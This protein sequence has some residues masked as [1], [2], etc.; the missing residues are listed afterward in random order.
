MVRLC[1]DGRGDHCFSS[2]FSQLPRP[3]RKSRRQT[4]RAPNPGTLLG[5]YLSGRMA[6]GDHDTE[7][8]ADFYSKALA[9]DPG[10]EIILEQAFLLEAAAAHWDRA[11]LL[12]RE[13]VKIEPS[14]RIAQFLLGCDA[15][16]RGDYK[17]ADEHFAAARQGPIADLTSTL[18]RA[19]V[20]Q[21]AGKTDEAFAT[22]DSLSDADWAQFYQ[23][24]HR[25]LIADVAGKHD[26]ARQAFAQ[27]FKKNPSTLRVADAY[28]RHAV[29]E[30]QPQARPARRSRPT[31][32]SPRRIPC[33]RRLLADIE[34][35]KVPPLL[36]VTPARWAR[37]GVLRHR[38]RS[39]RR[40]RA[41]HGHHLPAIRALR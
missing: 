15:F 8:A 24:Y 21:A 11:I 25:A 16:K 35:G 3:I 5:N 27:A 30:Q 29:N 38:R 37:R 33:L 7:A 26:V 10:N 4:P 18:A 34:A 17:E 40:G 28:A 14:H 19:W 36:V 23:R 2:Q 39:R 12:A 1:A 41:R 20:Q 9:E 32:P 13:L 31:S 22:L 6:R